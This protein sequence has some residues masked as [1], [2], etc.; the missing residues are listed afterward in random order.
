M[1]LKR[2]STPTIPFAASGL[3]SG[4]GGGH[5]ALAAA[6]DV[7]LDVSVIP[8][9]EPSS[10]SGSISDSGTTGNLSTSGNLSNSGGGQRRMEQGGNLVALNFGSKKA[11]IT[12]RLSTLLQSIWGVPPA[13][14]PLPQLAT[15][16]TGQ[17]NSPN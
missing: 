10:I 2:T 3:I 4:G 13:S 1:S 16:H 12:G 7:D 8:P 11:R 14:G 5:P 9:S 15:A 6:P 17:G